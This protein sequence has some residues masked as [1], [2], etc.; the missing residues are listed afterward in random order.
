MPFD[1]Q[2]AQRI[3][4]VVAR[5]KGFT[6][7]KMFGGVCFFL[8]GHVT[9]GVWKDSLILRIGPAKYED[10]LQASCVSEFDV[11]GRPMRGWVKVSPQGISDK[12]SLR[13]WIEQAVKFV[14]TLPAKAQ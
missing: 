11:T 8:N 6:E 14:R 3:R 7:K 5:R 9:C 10:V 12:E 4:Q 1:E 13:D 2:L